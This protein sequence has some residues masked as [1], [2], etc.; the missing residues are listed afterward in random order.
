[1]STNALIVAP[2][3]SDDDRL[4]ELWLKGEK[5]QSP[6]TQRAY[7]RDIETFR[8][9]MGF[10]SLRA[11]KVPDLELYAA[12]LTERGL[13][14]ATQRRMKA[15]V[16][17]LLA[18]GVRLGYLAANPGAAIESK[19][20]HDDPSKRMLAYRDVT[21]LIEL[22]PDPAKRAILHLCYVLAAR[23]S[24]LC[25]LRWSDVKEDEDGYTF[26]IMGKGGKARTLTVAHAEV[27]ADLDAL[28]A[29]S[30]P[31]LVGVGP[32]Q[33]WRYVQEAAARA[34]LDRDANGDERR[35]SPH[36]LRHS[37]A[38]RAAEKG[39]PM[40]LLRDYLGHASIATTNRYLHA[41]KGASLSAYL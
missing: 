31:T 1:M 9:A 39:A 3:V 10:K 6:C 8:Q 25:S 33:V 13:A 23:V 5:R 29:R 38:S 14:P 21:R 32:T 41:A 18:Y 27:R 16:R 11:V 17:S 15:S 36:W 34:G 24:E 4:I 12:A 37:L 2:S 19:P 28:R 30:T 26:R 35:I 40:P 7:R 20:L 22:E